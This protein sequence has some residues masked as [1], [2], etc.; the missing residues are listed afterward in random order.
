MN[1]II[2]VL[3][4]RLGYRFS[5]MDTYL[6]IVGGLKL[7]EPAADLPVALA[8]VSGITDKPMPDDVVAIGE[9]GLSGEVRAVSRI[10][11]RIS[12]AARLGFTRCIVPRS[13]LKDLKQEFPSMQVIGVRNIYE[14]IANIF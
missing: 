7:L 3:E 4:K 6:N 12:E 11:S 9:I 5:A 13:S 1:L 10:G 14:A 2:A 8:L